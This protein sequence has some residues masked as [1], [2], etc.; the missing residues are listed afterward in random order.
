MNRQ[1]T[2]TTRTSHEYGSL[3]PTT[4]A[5]SYLLPEGLSRSNIFDTTTTQEALQHFDADDAAISLSLNRSAP[6]QIIISSYA[7]FNHRRPLS[8]S[9]VQSPQPKAAFEVV[10]RKVLRETVDGVAVVN[11]ESYAVRQD[12]RASTPSGSAAG[13]GETSGRSLFNETRTYTDNSAHADDSSNFP[14]FVCNAKLATLVERAQVKQ[15]SQS[16]SR[17]NELIA[18]GSL[19]Q[20]SRRADSPSVSEAIG[21]ETSGYNRR[22]IPDASVP[23][24]LA[25]QA[26]AREELRHNRSSSLSGKTPSSALASRSDTVLTSHQLLTDVDTDIVSRRADGN[27]TALSSSAVGAAAAAVVGPNGHTRRIA[28]LTNLTTTT[29]TSLTTTII[30]EERYKDCTLFSLR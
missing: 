23:T 25:P 13:S 15:K 20:S 21:S 7:N 4:T 6:D 28:T 24:G 30:L 9:N 11:D 27:F 1:P 19:C 5:T 8:T 3:S 10:R 16:A 17:K 2:R 26:G 12:L 29:T 22:I 14:H 18:A